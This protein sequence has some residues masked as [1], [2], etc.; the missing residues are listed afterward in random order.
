[1]THEQAIALF[2]DFVECHERDDDDAAERIVEQLA[3]NGY[4]L[5]FRCADLHAIEEDAAEY[6]EFGRW[7]HADEE[8]DPT[9]PPI[10]ERSIRDECGVYWRHTLHYE[11]EAHP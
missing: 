4:K 2:H 9:S 5:D 1:M 7:M 10:A 8:D 11:P 3:S 6:G